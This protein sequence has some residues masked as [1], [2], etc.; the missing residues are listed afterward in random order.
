MHIT[1]Q[2]K[3]IIK[4]FNNFIQI[5][6]QVLHIPTYYYENFYLQYRY[7]IIEPYG[8][9]YSNNTEAFLI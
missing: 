5:L 4:N 1:Q 9:L 6:N 2:I 7:S 8:V 3:I